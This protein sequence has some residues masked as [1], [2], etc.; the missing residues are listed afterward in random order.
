MASSGEHGLEIEALRDR[1]SRLSEASLRINESLDLD[2]VLQ[3]ELDSARALTDLPYGVITTL[4]DSGL[5]KDFVT[6]G[7]TPEDHRALE[8]YLPD[9]ACWCTNTSADYGSRS[10]SAITEDYIGSLGLSDFLP[11]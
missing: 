6:S 3:E 10:E 2:V 4:D 7:M 11:F 9:G 5:P 8:N 1:L